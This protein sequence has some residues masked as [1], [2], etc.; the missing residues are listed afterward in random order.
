MVLKGFNGVFFVLRRISMCLLT[1]AAILTCVNTVSRYFFSFVIFGSEELSSYLIILLTFLMYPVMEAGN[2]HLKMDLFDKMVKNERIKK[3]VLV[4]RG[5]VTMGICG[6]IAYYGWRV[7]SVAYRF[8]AASPALKIP[9]AI[10]FG[11]VTIS[12]AIAILAW[13]CVIVFNKRRYF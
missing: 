11:I 10:V 3:V 1:F 9:T 6:I 8:Q 7:T 2:N 13:I 12:L 5:L 4:I